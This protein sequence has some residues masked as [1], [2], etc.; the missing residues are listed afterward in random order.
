MGEERKFMI[1]TL[2]YDNFLSL[3]KIILNCLLRKA[4]IPMNAKL[5]QCWDLLI[6]TKCPLKYDKN[7][8]KSEM[9]LIQGTLQHSSVQP[10]HRQALF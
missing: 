9:K 10:G 5:N 3:N 6:F 4:E 2:T 8:L 7:V 1:F